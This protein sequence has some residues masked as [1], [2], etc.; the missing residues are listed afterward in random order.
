[1]A[2]ISSTWVEPGS[3]D[4]AGFDTHTPDTDRNSLLDQTQ[5]Y[6]Q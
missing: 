5:E 6:L 3:V 1:M 4:R 2:Q